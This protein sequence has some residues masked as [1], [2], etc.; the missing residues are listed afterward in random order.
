MATEYVDAAG[1]KKIMELAK[2]DN[3]KTAEQLQADYNAKFSSMVDSINMLSENM[4]QIQQNVNEQITTINESIQNMS[5]SISESI[6]NINDKIDTMHTSIEAKIDSLQ[7]DFDNL[8]TQVNSIN[9]TVNGLS[10]DVSDIKTAMQDMVVNIE[11]D[12]ETGNFIVY[13]YDGTVVRSKV[14]DSI[15]TDDIDVIAAGNGDADGDGIP[16]NEGTENT[17]EE[18]T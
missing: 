14:V 1:A 4:N 2:Q 11:N 7:Q 17:E 18:T 12:P 13:H 3:V 5:N 15:S 16:D 6:G 8:D 9:D 10:S